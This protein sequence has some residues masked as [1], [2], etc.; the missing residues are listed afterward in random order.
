MGV[1]VSCQASAFTL[2]AN[3]LNKTCLKGF[4]VYW[5]QWDLV[6]LAAEKTAEEINP[7]SLVEKI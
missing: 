5:S 7:E 2:E 6:P 3:G 1:D 4:G